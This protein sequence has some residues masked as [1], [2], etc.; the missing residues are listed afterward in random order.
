[1]EFHRADVGV[2]RSTQAKTAA[3]ASISEAFQGR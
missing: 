2:F 3:D 1:M